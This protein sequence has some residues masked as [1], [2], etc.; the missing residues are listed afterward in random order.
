MFLTY[1]FAPI[2]ILFVSFVTFLVLRYNDPVNLN[3]YKDKMN[4]IPPVVCCLGILLP[5]TVLILYGIAMKLGPQ[6]SKTGIKV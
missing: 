4:G 6:P 1:D 5:V 3:E 2:F